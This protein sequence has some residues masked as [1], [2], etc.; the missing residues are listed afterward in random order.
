MTLSKD[1]LKNLTEFLCFIIQDQNTKDG[2]GLKLCFQLFLAVNS[3][4]LEEE[5][6]INVTSH[7]FNDS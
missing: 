6:I 1:K 7:I 5:K 4:V 2:K 3:Y